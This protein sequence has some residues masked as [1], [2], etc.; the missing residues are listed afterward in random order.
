MLWLWHTCNS[1]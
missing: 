1:D